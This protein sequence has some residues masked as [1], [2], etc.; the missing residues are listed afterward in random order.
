MIGNYFF[1]LEWIVFGLV[2]LIF[3]IIIMV[4]EI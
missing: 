1:Y 4:S 3:I 2:E